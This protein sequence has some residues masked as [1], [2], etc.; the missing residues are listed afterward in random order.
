M[1]SQLEPLRF[2]RRGKGAQRTDNVVAWTALSRY[3]FNQQM[4]GVSLAPKSAFSPLN[5]HW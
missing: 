4:I 2:G 5:E 1:M 3:R